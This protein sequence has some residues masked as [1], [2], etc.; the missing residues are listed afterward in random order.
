RSLRPAGH[1]LLSRLVHR[2]HPARGLRARLH[3]PL[4][5]PGTDRRVLPRPDPVR[6]GLR[7][8]ADV[9]APIRADLRPAGRRRRGARAS[10]CAR[11]VR[12]AR[13]AAGG[14]GAM[15]IIATANVEAL[16]IFAIVLSVTLVIT[17]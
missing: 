17:Y 2:L 7:A 12:G 10:A 4:G 1:D 9:P 11:N 16:V 14:D 8:R 13:A 6:D 15:M 5:L 3:G